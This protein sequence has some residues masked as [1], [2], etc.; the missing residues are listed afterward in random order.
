VLFAANLSMLWAELPLAERF[1][2]AAGAGFGAVELWWPG[3]A[4]ARTLP[5]LT[6][7]WDQRLVLLNFDA[8]DMAAGDRGLAADP[9]RSEYLRAHVPD[10]LAIAA[11]CGCPRLNLLVG[12]RQQRYSEAEQLA[13]ARDNV[14]WA[15]DRA[16]EAGI[17]VMIEALNPMDNGPCLLTTTRAAAGFV[18]AVARPNVRLQYDAYHMQRT[19]GDLTATLDAYWELI[20]HIQIADVPGRHEPGTGE[21]NYPFLLGHIAAKG[22]QGAIGA[23]YHPSTARTEDSLG[24][25]EAYRRA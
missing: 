18:A 22:Y 13:C 2:R 16:A 11:A 25:L 10:A 8:G 21:I 1:E 19:E 7:R 15:A 3:A 14:A 5:E 17:E 9:G 12:L 4:A 24:W 23:E 20:G 6:A